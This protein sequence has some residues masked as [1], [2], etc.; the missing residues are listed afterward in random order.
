MTKPAIT[1]TFTEAYP[2]E[3]SMSF[4]RGVI[5]AAEV[6]IT[7]FT[8]PL[9]KPRLWGIQSCAVVKAGPYTKLPPKEEMRAQPYIM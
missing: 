1:M 2:T 3:D 9:A 8:K 5:T 6:P 4:Q 7:K